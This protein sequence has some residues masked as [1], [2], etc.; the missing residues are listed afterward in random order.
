[1]IPTDFPIILFPEIKDWDE[2]MKKNHATEK[3]VW[4]KFAKKNSGKTSINYAQALDV[5][6]CY[7]WIDSLTKKLD[8]S[9]YIQK[10]T[11]RGLR[12]VWSKINTG[13]IERLTKAGLMQASG[14]AAVEAAKK[15]GR[16]EKAYD[17]PSNIQLPEDFL[18]A[19]KKNKKAEA[20]FK[21]LNKTNTYAITWRLQT[22]KKSAIRTKRIETI[23][24]MLER[25]EKLHE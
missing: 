13:H 19:L 1:M 18:L 9:F 10:F 24:A 8:D 23:I 22:A 3:G 15:D 20:F 25:N 11:P 7:G 5:A 14:I 6:L 12:S 16:W 21:T 4:I 2:W 17:S